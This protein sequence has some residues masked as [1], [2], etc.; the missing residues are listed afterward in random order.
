M[1]IHTYIHACMHAR[2]HAYI[3]TYTHTHIHIHT[4]I[5][6]HKPFIPT[7]YNKH[8]YNDYI[9]I[10]IYVLYMHVSPWYSHAIPMISPYLFPSGWHPGEFLRLPRRRGLGVPGDAGHSQKIV[11]IVA[12]NIWWIIIENG[13]FSRHSNQ[14]KH[15]DCNIMVNSLQRCRHSKQDNSPRREGSLL[16]GPAKGF[17]YDGNGFNT[18]DGRNPAPVDGLSHYHPIVCSVS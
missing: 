6:T 16:G 14:K 12:N 5:H 7:W 10:Y 4:Y 15:W 9:Y 18:V 17:S 3:Q 1:I 13:D 2:M 8:S 11:G